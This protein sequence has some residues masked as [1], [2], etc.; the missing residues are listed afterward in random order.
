MLKNT[1]LMLMLLVCIPASAV[2]I[3]HKDANRLGVYGKIRASHLLSDNAKEDGDNT[4]IRFGLRGETQIAEHLIGY[5]NFQMQF[6]GSKYEGEEKNSWTRLGFAGISHDRAGSFDYGRNWGIMYDLGAW[7]DVLPEFGAATLFHTDN[8]MAQRATTLATYRNRDFFG[9]V[10]GLNLAVQF[11]GKNEGGR[12]LNKQ[13]GNGYGISATYN[14]DSGLSL[15]GVYT[16]SERTDEQK[17]YGRHVASGP[18]AESYIVSAKYS[19]DGLYL[20]ALYGETSNM[21]AFAS[22]TNI[23]NKTQAL[24]LVA[25]YR[26]N[27]GFEPSIGYLQSKGKDLSGYNTDNNLVQFINLGAMYYFNNTVAAYANY[28]INLLDAN[29]FTS[30]AGLKTDNTLVL[31]LVYQL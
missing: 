26:F 25:K 4:Y 20:A 19:A 6:Q 15:G 14:F 8:F 23:A 10:D 17:G 31:G 5:G 12:A 1:T 13:N 27:N 9:L 28:K 11:Q 3:Y 30:A 16:H 22:S 21:T 2:E 7:T 18:Y 24:E 29:N